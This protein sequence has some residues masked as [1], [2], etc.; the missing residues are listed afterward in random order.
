MIY[1]DEYGVKKNPI[2]FVLPS[3]WISSSSNKSQRTRLVDDIEGLDY[4]NDDCSSDDVE[5]VHPSM[6][7]KEAFRIRN[8]SKTYE[9]LFSKESTRAVK[10]ISLNIYENQITAL[11]GRNGKNWIV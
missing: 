6:I 1:L 10:G 8:L 9:S 2:Y 11:I 5:K 7:G 3:F 4:N